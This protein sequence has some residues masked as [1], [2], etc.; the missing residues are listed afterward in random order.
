MHSLNVGLLQRVYTALY[1]RR[2]SH[3]SEL[4][5]TNVVEEFKAHVS[6]PVR[7]PLKS[8]GSVDDSRHAIFITCH[9]K[10]FR[11]EIQKERDHLADHGEDA[12]MGSEL[13]LGR[14]AEGV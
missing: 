9:L 2:L 11:W 8:Y 7:F 1:H 13:I 4:F 6:C 10:G 3:R 14:L 12:R 5:L